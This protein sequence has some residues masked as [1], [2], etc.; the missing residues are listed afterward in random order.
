[1]IKLN[2]RTYI[3]GGIIAAILVVASL[4]FLLSTYLWP[5]VQE[6]EAGRPVDVV[7]NFYEPW[8]AAVQATTTDPFALGLAKSPILSKD[9]RNQ[10]NKGKKHA[11]TEPDPV[12]CQT[13]IPTTVSA[14]LISELEETAQVLVM[15]SDR[16]DPEQAVVTLRKLNEGWYIDGISCSPGEFGPEREFSFEREGHLLKSVPA[17]YNPEYWHL[18]FTQ[19]EQAGN[20]VPLFFDAE[21][22]CTTR[23]KNETTCDPSLFVEASEASVQGQMSET[24]VTVKRLNLE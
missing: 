20:V 19:N 4:L 12:L 13:N 17:P 9:V 14:R 5:S 24:G 21:S 3:I 8:L 11:P 16:T 15:S 23:G 10:I 7:L 18:V 6:V 2:R 1:M 22:K